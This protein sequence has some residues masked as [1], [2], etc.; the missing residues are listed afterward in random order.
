MSKL[1]N[2]LAHLH[3]LGNS[4]TDE[5]HK[6]QAEEV[7]ATLEEQKKQFE[8]YQQDL[9]CFYFI[10]CFINPFILLHINLSFL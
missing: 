1:P 4:C 9:V 2:L 8:A 6:K 5:Q 3:E 7:I 10:I